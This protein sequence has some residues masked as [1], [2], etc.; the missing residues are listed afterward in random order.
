MVLLRLAGAYGNSL[1]HAP[2]PTKVYTAALIAATGDA[3]AQFDGHPENYDVARGATFALFG[4]T[5]TGAFQHALFGWL[6]SICTGAALAGPWFP[7][8]RWLA[9]AEC[10]LLN[11]FVVIP[12]LYLPLF[13]LLSGVTRGMGLRSI[14]AEARR[15]Y[16][17]LLRWNWAFWLPVQCAFFALVPDDLLVPFT[18]VAGL[19]WSRVLS[20]L[21]YAT[22]HLPALPPARVRVTH[23]LPAAS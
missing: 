12:L 13:L 7:P 18:C 6:G 9:A 4:A 2:L 3:L 17:P 10:T 5:Y 19:L 15:K 23:L 8:G 14:V 16:V 1:I 21:V 22:Q 20:T 11:Q